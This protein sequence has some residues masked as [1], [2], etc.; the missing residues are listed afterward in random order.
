[1]LRLI[2]ICFLLF[3]GSSY[4][5]QTPQY[6]QYIKNQ[7]MINPAAAGAY[8]FLGITLGGRMQ[9]AGFE[10]APKTSYLNFSAP[11]DKFKNAFMRRTFGKVRRNNKSVKHP[12]MRRGS[13]SHAFG[14]QVVA[15]QYGAFRSF[16]FMGTYAIHIPMNRSYSLSFGTSL[17]LSNR[18]FLQ[19]KAQ[20]LSMLTN[21]GQVDQTYNSYA[22]GQGAQ[23]TME[24]EAG[25]YF[26]GEGLFFGVS[27]NQLTGDL[28]KFGNNTINLDP[29][30]HLFFT[31]GYKIQVN[32]GLSITPGFLVKYVKP[33][34][35]SIEGSIQFDFNERFW[36]GGSYRH[37]D[38]IVGVIGLNISNSFRMGYS[39]DFSVSRFNTVSSGG[40]EI[41]LGLMLGR[42]GGSRASI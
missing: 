28:V 32:N 33:A 27:A 40:H 16:K 2:F 25:M 26:Y 31:G 8:N 13:L 24:V 39:Y 19:D 3:A 36:V 7:Y 6:S 30:V 37:K 10:N 9:W 4:G 41:V 21:T 34:P 23:N 15:D 38:A 5:Q 14:G 17:G 42:S 1:M 12:V 22:S 29:K 20:V 18:S 35:L 11:S